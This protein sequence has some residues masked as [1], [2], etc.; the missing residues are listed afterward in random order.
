MFMYVHTHAFS[1]T[2]GGQRSTLGVLLNHVQP[3]FSE[4]GPLFDLARLAGQQ[5]PGTCPTLASQSWVYGCVPPT[6]AV[7]AG[8]LPKGLRLTLQAHYPGT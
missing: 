5:A 4:R 2:Y 7:E 3:S 8:D 1:C 6:P